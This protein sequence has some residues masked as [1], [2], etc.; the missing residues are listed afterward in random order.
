MLT[1]S[2]CTNFVAQTHHYLT[3]V[4]VKGSIGFRLMHWNDGS[5]V[6]VPTAE[7]MYVIETNRLTTL[8]QDESA[9][10]AS[11]GTTSNQANQQNSRGRTSSIL[12][13]KPGQLS[14]IQHGQCPCCS[15]SWNARLRI[16]INGRAACFYCLREWALGTHTMRTTSV[17]KI[18]GAYAR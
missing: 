16:Y 15:R 7:V 12:P 5:K 11:F 2:E 13:Q 9:K 6:A 18:G 3:Y 14:W 10:V 8:A 1:F 17:E 4:S